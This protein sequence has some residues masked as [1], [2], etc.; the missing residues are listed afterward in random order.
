MWQNIVKSLSFM[1]RI[2]NNVHRKKVVD[3][4]RTLLFENSFINVEF[5]FVWHATHLKL[6]KCG[7]VLSNILLATS[8]HALLNIFLKS[9]NL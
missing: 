4:D 7:G 2:F 5:K 1:S 3:I 9:E 8:L 6:N